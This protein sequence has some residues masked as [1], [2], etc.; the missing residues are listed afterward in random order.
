MH[1][2]VLR[3]FSTLYLANIRTG[4]L[5]LA[6]LFHSP[7][8]GSHE[9]ATHFSRGTEQ[10]GRWAVRHLLCVKG[11]CGYV[12]NVVHEQPSPGQDTGQGRANEQK[13]HIIQPTDHFWKALVT[14]EAR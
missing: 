12:G 5:S 7:V 13:L 1:H 3:S 4:T 6:E 14:T 11:F 9:L 10:S 2:H 8:T